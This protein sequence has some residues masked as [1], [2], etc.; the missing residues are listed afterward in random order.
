MSKCCGAKKLRQKNSGAIPS[1]MTPQCRCMHKG[2][3]IDAK[4][5]RWRLNLGAK[6]G[7]GWRGRVKEEE[8]EGGAGKGKRGG[9]W[10]QTSFC[11]TFLKKTRLNSANP[12]VAYA[13]VIRGRGSKCSSFPVLHVKRCPRVHFEQVLGHVRPRGSIFT[14]RCLRCCVSLEYFATLQS[15]FHRNHVHHPSGEL[16]VQCVAAW[17]R[18]RLDLQNWGP[19]KLTTPRPATK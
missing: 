13:L 14:P 10:K 7:E 2:N 15:H 12:C 3:A 4:E 16:G 11:Q 1:R 19:Q 8:G 18:M 6:K 9:G 17:V 5:G